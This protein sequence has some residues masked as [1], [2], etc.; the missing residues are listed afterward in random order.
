MKRKLLSLALGFVLGTI[1]IFAFDEIQQKRYLR[2]LIRNN[3][4]SDF[5]YPGWTRFK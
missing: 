1:A 2:D 4:E 5:N 3:P